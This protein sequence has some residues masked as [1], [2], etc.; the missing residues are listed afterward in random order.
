MIRRTRQKCI[1]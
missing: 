1:G